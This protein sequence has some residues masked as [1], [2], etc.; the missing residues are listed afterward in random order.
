MSSLLSSYFLSF[1]FISFHSRSIS[2]FF[3]FFFDRYKG[4]TICAHVFVK[5]SYSFLYAK[6]NFYI[7]LYE[8]NTTFDNFFPIR[9]AK[10]ARYK[11]KVFIPATPRLITWLCARVM[12]NS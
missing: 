11:I 12:S 7:Q 2:F 10:K 8:S 5:W 9:N 1:P 3:F 6:N 4:Y